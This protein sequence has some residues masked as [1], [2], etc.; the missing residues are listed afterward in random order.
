MLIAV[1]GVVTL[2]DLWSVNKRYL[3]EDSF[4]DKSL[5]E[6]PI[7]EREVDQLI[8]L[9]Q[10]L[11]Y[12]V[13]DLTSS[14]FQDAGASFFHKSLGGYHAAKLMRFQELLEHQFDANI[15][16]DVL[17][18]LNVR[19]LITRDAENN[20][21]RIQRRSSAMGN[22]WFVRNVNFVNGNRA[23]MEALDTFNPRRDA[24]VNQGLKD[25]FGTMSLGQPDSTSSIALTSYHPDTMRYEYTAGTNLFAVFSEIFY[26]RGW[27]A[28]VDG[29]EVPIIRTN[30]LLRGLALP[31]GEH[32][33]EF[34]F[35]PASMKISNTVSLIASIIL[36]LGLGLA[37]GL[38]IRQRKESSDKNSHEALGGRA[39]SQAKKMKSTF[40]KR[41]I[42]VPLL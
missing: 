37:I 12:R 36:V 7:P 38:S 41:T 27:K 32:Q 13:F 8:H 39:V 2:A 40:R 25:K 10:D 29:E 30:Y 21:E 11:S 23:E 31:A 3:N 16:E 28:Y 9:D 5:Y 24:M 17:D 19:Y 4:V 18:M 6:R 20:S 33:V 35:A 14:P 42:A 26:D 34:V 22:A 1:L 15:N